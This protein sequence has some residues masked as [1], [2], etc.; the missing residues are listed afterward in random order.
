MHTRLQSGSSVSEEI[1]HLVQ[2]GTLTESWVAA[3]EE[4]LANG[5]DLFNLIVA[6]ANPIADAAD[7]SVIAA[8]DEL[9][10]LE[11]HQRVETV[12][13]TI[14]PAAMAR[15]A[16]SREEFYDRYR[17]M[18]P[19]LHRHAKNRRGLYFERLI[20]YPLPARGKCANQI[21]LIIRDLQGQL[22]NHRPRR[23]IY[24]AQVFAPGKDR[25]PS[26]FPCLSSLSFQLDKP[27]LRLTATYR[28]QYY[29]ERALGNFLGLAR[30]QRF[31]ADEVEL[32]LGPLTI[33]AFHAKLDLGVRKATQLL[34]SC[35]LP[36]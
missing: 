33:H 12:A 14:F 13:N 1:A 16:R 17:S 18:L 21:E 31:I 7:A 28:N 26:G 20:E 6:I 2:S 10:A 35:R 27:R 34:E 36:E 5:G 24:E 29:F 8:L 30:L 25:L 19:L 22:K 15:A 9:L 32:A 3:V 11:G 4:L 23:S